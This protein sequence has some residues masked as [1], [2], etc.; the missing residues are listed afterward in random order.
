MITVR[1]MQTDEVPRLAEIDRTEHV[2]HIYVH[3]DG[4]LARKE[5]DWHIS[6]W[7]PMA[8]LQQPLPKGTPPPQITGPATIETW[9][10][11]LIAGSTMLGAFDGDALVGFAIYCP[12]I[13]PETAQLEALYVSKDYRGQ[14]IG[15]LLLEKVEELARADGAKKLYVSSIPTTA[16]V[17]FYM[18]QGFQPTADVNP[19]LY[20]LEPEDIHMTKPL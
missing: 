4:T 20:E 9:R 18:S 6:R 14:K 16:T 11:T 12:A 19:R 5:V 3:S 2:T 15:V 7:L 8:P 10:P 13:S 1:R 17:D